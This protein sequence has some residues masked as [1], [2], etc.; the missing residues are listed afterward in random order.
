MQCL[1]ASINAGQA[2]PH[3]VPVPDSFAFFG[4]GDGVPVWGD[5]AL[6]AQI[7]EKVVDLTIIARD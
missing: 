2:S 1:I 3:S 5:S 4:N 6:S 7:E